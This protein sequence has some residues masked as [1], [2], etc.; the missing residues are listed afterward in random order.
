MLNNL[1]ANFKRLFTSVRPV[2]REREFDSIGAV[3]IM[4]AALGWELVKLLVTHPDIFVFAPIAAVGLLL[5]LA[6]VFGIG[7]LG[8]LIVQLAAVFVRWRVSEE[9]QSKRA[10]PAIVIGIV[11]LVFLG[12]PEVGE[13]LA[14]WQENL[15]RY[16]P[17]EPETL[18]A[19]LKL[20][21]SNRQSIYGLMIMAAFGCLI[22]SRVYRRFRNH[23]RDAL[24]LFKNL[25][26]RRNWILPAILAI[27]IPATIG[28]VAYRPLDPAFALLFIE[29]AA[30]VLWLFAPLIR[31][32]FFFILAAV[33]WFVPA[34]IVD[35]RVGTKDFLWYVLFVLFWGAWLVSP[36]LLRT[37]WWRIVFWVG[38][39]AFAVY[40]AFGPGSV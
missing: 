15:F 26:T 24:T 34:L 17:H 4:L 11:G 28:F 29:L 8:W 35:Y 33:A 37:L 13:K 27:L 10:W 12:I 18:K 22:F 6:A 25:T 16:L 19:C 40:I 3:V 20:I 38:T 39:L 14:W 5:I 31:A 1:A 30:L 36:T 9:A 7:A 32:Y 2:I 21:H 23:L